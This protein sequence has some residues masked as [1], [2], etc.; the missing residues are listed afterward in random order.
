MLFTTETT[1]ITEKS[2]L[3]ISVGSVLPVVNVLD[4]HKTCT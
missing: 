3:K 4:L 1:K 2:P